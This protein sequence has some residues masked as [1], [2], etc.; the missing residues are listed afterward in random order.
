MARIST[1]RIYD[2]PA[3]KDGLRILVDRLWPR[4]LTREA[5]AIDEWAKELAPSKE[6]RTW[7]DHIPENW[8]G[9]QRKYKAELRRNK[10]LKEFLERHQER[11]TI[12]LLYA[13]KYDHL[14]HALVLKQVLEK[15]RE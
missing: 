3:K 13:T 4:G 1:K 11:K 6:L 9:F 7:F 15:S 10:A 8:E 5:A 2:K 14:T 12:T